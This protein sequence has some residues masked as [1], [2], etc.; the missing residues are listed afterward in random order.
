MNYFIWQS[1]C[2]AGPYTQNQLREL[3]R[4]GAVTG[5]SKYRL[6][7]SGDWLDCS[8]LEE[9]LEADEPIS[10]P[11]SAANFLSALRGNSNYAVARS[12]IRLTCAFWI[13]GLWSIFIFGTLLP[14]LQGSGDSIVWPAVIALLQT[15]GLIGLAQFAM[16]VTDAADCLVDMARRN[17]QN[18]P[19]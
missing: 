12:M 14:R 4:T 11:P 8:D 7:D 3:W 18:P 16:A 17:S 6:A 1:E 5:A 2:E 19:H 13:I 15:F 10:P 9:L